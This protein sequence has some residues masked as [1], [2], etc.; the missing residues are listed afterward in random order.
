[1]EACSNVDL[2][3]LL[4]GYEEYGRTQLSIFDL[5]NTAGAEVIIT[6]NDC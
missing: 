2:N 6:E 1:M 3:G 5:F 4:I